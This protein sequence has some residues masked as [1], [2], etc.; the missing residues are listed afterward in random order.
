MFDVT[1]RVTHKF[2]LSIKCL[3]RFPLLISRS[4]LKFKGNEM[5]DGSNLQGLHMFSV[6]MKLVKRRNSFFCQIKSH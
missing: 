4:M 5:D 1:M 3:Y 6:F 2:I